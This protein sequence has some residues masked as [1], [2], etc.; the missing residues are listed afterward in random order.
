MFDDPLARSVERLLR[1]VPET[2]SPRRRDAE[3]HAD[4]EALFALVAAGLV[5]RRLGLAFE[6]GSG[7]PSLRFQIEVTGEAG[8]VAAMR[9]AEHRLFAAWMEQ[10]R[11]LFGFR[12][13]DVTIS[14]R[15]EP[16]D[17]WRLTRLGV[18]ARED[19]DIDGKTEGEWM[20]VGCRQR[21][22]L[23]VLRRHWFTD[24]PPVAGDGTAHW[25]GEHPT[26]QAAP[27]HRRLIFW[28]AFTFR[29][30][31][32][33]DIR[34]AVAVE[35]QAGFARNA[36]KAR[37]AAQ[38]PECASVPSEPE[39]QALERR[40]LLVLR[41]I[42]SKDPAELLTVAEIIESM[43]LVDR[44]STRT[45]EIA[46]NGLIE[47]GLAERPQGLRGGARATTRGRALARRSASSACR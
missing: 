45:V 27:W 14:A 31:L 30:R 21:T 33:R 5:G 20:H 41:A 43:P 44:L 8:L 28:L 2:W 35:V 42:A 10:R 36:S 19:L 6:F 9:S 1:T 47:M 34:Q 7:T 32:V 23:F 3:S 11:S 26:G 15:P 38:H 25:I 4:E 22:I 13:R 39:C 18:L 46:L 12:R 17:D 24:R 40:Q 37:P 29:P 16:P